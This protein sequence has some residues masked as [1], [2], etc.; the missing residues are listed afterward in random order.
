MAGMNIPSS[1]IKL[2]AEYVRRKLMDDSDRCTCRIDEMA[3]MAWE[4]M[5]LCDLVDHSGWDFIRLMVQ[6]N[7]ERYDPLLYSSLVSMREH[8]FEEFV[9]AYG[10]RPTSL[11]RYYTSHANLHNSLSHAQSQKCGRFS[12]KFSKSPD[13]QS[14]FGPPSISKDF[15][16]NMPTQ[17]MT[18]QQSPGGPAIHLTINPRR[19]RDVADCAVSSSMEEDGVKEILDLVSSGDSMDAVDSTLAC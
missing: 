10:C 13:R 16:A 9:A 1:T 7:E 8:H 17:Q 5:L 11:Q 18:V 14:Q 2:I 6:A 4:T 3:D 19:G 15:L 12:G